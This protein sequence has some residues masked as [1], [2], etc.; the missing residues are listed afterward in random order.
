MMA[1]GCGSADEPLAETSAPAAQAEVAPSANAAEDVPSQPAAQAA[2]DE[3]KPEQA[4]P[5]SPSPAATAQFTP[6]FPDRMELFEP[7]KRAQSAARQNDVEGQSVEL[8]GFVNVDQPR[9]LLDIDGVISPIA[10]G[11][12]KYGVRVISIQPPNVV[13]ERNRSRWIATLE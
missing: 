7:P 11:G 2:A 4:E 6:P 1:S 9:V 12:E 3:A 13:L 8:K 10:E 5:E